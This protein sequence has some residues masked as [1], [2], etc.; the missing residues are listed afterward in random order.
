MVK[1]V[2]RGG[3]GVDT[4]HKVRVRFPSVVMEVI[5]LWGHNRAGDRPEREARRDERRP[6][7][8]Q[9]GLLASLVSFVAVVFLLQNDGGAL[10]NLCSGLDRDHG[11]GL[12]VSSRCLGGD[13]RLV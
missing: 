5:G 8:R 10:E 1:W 13:L 11:E 12:V 3:R 4:D 6:M 9:R 2:L 7:V